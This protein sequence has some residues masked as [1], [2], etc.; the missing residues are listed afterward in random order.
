MKKFLLIVFSVIALAII[1]LYVFIPGKLEISKDEHMKFPA[2]SASRVLNDTSAW[3]K[4]WP[5]KDGFFKKDKNGKEVFYYRG[6]QYQ[7]IEK[8]D[9]GV[10]VMI[11]SDK[12]AINS[13]IDMIKINSDSIMLS[14]KCNITTGFNPVSRFLKYRQAKEIK[15]N[16]TVILGS[17]RSFLEDKK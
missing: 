17:L 6:F 14:W 7:L 12:L 11:N 1:C 13:K 2:T 9:S 15:Q 8:Y 4:W 5:E 16:M 10:N 3:Q